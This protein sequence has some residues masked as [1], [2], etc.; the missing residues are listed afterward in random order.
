MAEDWGKCSRVA[1]PEDALM[2][3]EGAVLEA[4]RS[5]IRSLMCRFLMGGFPVERYF[6]NAGGRLKAT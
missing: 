6:R 2:L 1:D 4:A 5:A 3:M